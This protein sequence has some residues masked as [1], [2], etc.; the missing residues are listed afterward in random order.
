M[1]ELFELQK[2]AIPEGLYESLC[3][4]I[5]A[6]AKALEG[7]EKNRYSCSV[8]AL[9]NI[10]MTRRAPI[11]FIFRILSSGTHFFNFSISIRK[12]KLPK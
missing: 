12:S 8:F 10:A 2:E 5:I 7:A 11:D 4:V 6:Q 3:I 1:R 9:A